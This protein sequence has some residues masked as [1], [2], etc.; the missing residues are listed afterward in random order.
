MSADSN[1]SRHESPVQVSRRPA[2]HQNTAPASY[3]YLSSTHFD[4]PEQFSDT[5]A[6]EVEDSPHIS[7]HP[8]KQW[9]FAQST[10]VEIKCDDI[11]QFRSS[12]DRN[13]FV[14]MVPRFERSYLLNI[15]K[16]MRWVPFLNNRSP[17]N[18]H[19]VQ[20]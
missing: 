4:R 10:T 14:S 7:L 12:Q 18:R 5:R 8:T 2:I 9:R 11:M 3:F 6:S 20:P 15:T 1:Q 17:K 19:A 16:I 13:K